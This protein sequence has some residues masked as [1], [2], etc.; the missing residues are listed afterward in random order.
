[1]LTG[2]V[3]KIVTELDRRW[4]GNARKWCFINNIEPTGYH[5]D[6]LNGPNCIRLLSKINELLDLMPE[7]LKKF[8]IALI[9]LDSVRKACFGQKLDPDF[10]K[11]IKYFEKRYK[12]LGISIT[13]KAHILFT[14]VFEWCTIY[15]ESLGIYSEQSGESLHHD[16]KSVWANFYR[17]STH[18]DYKKQLLN[19]VVTYNSLH[20]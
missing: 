2:T 5:G 6:A 8:A 12:D 13:P 1:M 20:I 15:Q 17:P 10:G 7:N 14:H 4:D 19:A 3:N 9:A 16:F 18:K 11:K